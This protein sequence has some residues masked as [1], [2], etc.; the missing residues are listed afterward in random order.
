MLQSW[1]LARLQS[2]ASRYRCCVDLGCGFG[3]WAELFA[4]VADEVHGCELAP[5]FV[6]QARERVPHGNFECADLRD[7][8]IPAGADLVYIGAVLMYLPERD[9]LDVL[10]RVRAAA[11]PGAI[12]AWRDWCA[13]NLG[14]RTVYRTP[15]R[16][17][18]HRTPAELCWLAELAGFE[19]IELRSAY[20]I[21]AE[22]IGKR[23][24]QWPLRGLA[25]LGTLPFTRSSHTLLLKSS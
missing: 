10:Q 7:Y 13:F 16:M 25:R 14:R 4:T 23:A 5:V 1:T 19:I 2:F 11:T 20:S 22:M 6:D 9:V 21:Y 24:L 8:R 18:I 17:S 3:D 15:E 12:V